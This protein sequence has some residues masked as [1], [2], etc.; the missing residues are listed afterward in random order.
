MLFSINFTS[1]PHRIIWAAAGLLILAL[2]WKGIDPRQ[3]R[4]ARIPDSDV[5]TSRLQGDILD[6]TLIVLLTRIYSAFGQDD[7]G[8]IYDGIASAVLPELVTDLY[9]QRRAAQLAEFSDGTASEI[10]QVEL[11]SSERIADGPMVQA[12]WRVVGIVGHEDHRHE[13]M[14]IYSARL[15][16]SPELGEWRFSG[17]DLDQVSREELPQ[18]LDDF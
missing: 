9:L 4:S 8:A 14:N 12:K 18:F 2:V 15:T 13:R 1:P 3:Q 7:E 11:A 16:L 17:F 5:V 10:L 6:Q